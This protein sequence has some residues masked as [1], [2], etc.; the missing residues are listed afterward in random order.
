MYDITNE[1][2]FKFLKSEYKTLTLVS[3]AYLL[4]TLVMFWP[5][6][7]GFGSTIV[8]SGDAY[9]SM[10]NL[11][12]SG[13]ATFTL[14]TNLYF[15]SLL[16]S[17]IGA[18]LVVQDL[19]PLAGILGA[20]LQYFGLA[21]EY[22]TI[23]ILG[24]VL[25]GLFTYALAYYLARDRHAAFIAG[26]VFAFAPVHIAHAYAHLNWTSVEFIPLF[27]L[28]FLLFFK[29]RRQIFIFGAAIS[30]V[31]LTFIGDLLQSVMTIVFVA[32]FLVYMLAFDRKKVLD[33]GFFMGLC[34]IAVIFLLIGSP[35]L[36]HIFGSVINSG[37]V[38]ESL[39]VS[40][41]SQNIQFS[42]DL[43]AFFLPSSFNIVFNKIAGSYYQIY[44]ADINEK[45]SYIGY[46]ILFLSSL[47]ILYNYKSRRFPEVFLWLFI[48]IVF[49]WLALGPYIFLAG[50]NT[51][52]PGI[53]L[54]YANIP[55]FNLLREPGRFDVIAELGFAILAAFG[56]VYLSEAVAKRYSTRDVKTYL[57]AVLLA[58]ILIEYNG[59]PSNALAQQWYMNVSIP[60]VFY[61][62]GNSTQNYTVMLLPDTPN[63]TLPAFYLGESMYYQT[64][65]KKPIIGGYTSRENGT[66]YLSTYMIPLSIASGN[67]E[68]GNGFAYSS[69]I[70]ENYTRLTLLLLQEDNVHYVGIIK[71]AYNQGS[72]DELYH[73]LDGVFG[74]PVYNG[75]AVVLFDAQEAIL[76]NSGY[77]TA[78]TAGE[79]IPGS[80]LC[81]YGMQCNKTIT[82][83][84]FGSNVRGIEEY[85]PNSTSLTLDF[86][87]FSPIGSELYLYANGNLVKSINLTTVPRNYSA[88]VKFSSGFN[89]VILYVHNITSSA[90]QYGY[91]GIDN[92]T[93]S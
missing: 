91:Y 68:V 28:F 79:W 44:Q 70:I 4:I 73:Y 2:M 92:I 15:T 20:P 25:T 13:Y 50:T 5:V 27:I 89:Q 78:Y 80:S 16:Y 65:F 17:P 56:F 35:F 76:K 69:P 62:I 60:K 57:F 9:Q 7:F 71:Q 88:S 34:E 36:I 43:A 12:W 83:M 46:S 74:A 10:W 63:Q 86:N 93:F 26:T 21:A 31:L 19:M 75:N 33:K 81:S 8:H 11:W 41:I 54:I 87:A 48:I 64:A 30:F 72:F 14:H 90:Y 40:T 58:L 66:Q 67:L 37:I 18:N 59:M 55:L 53:Y 42:D 85:S 29:E 1:S 39:G 52:L 23:F 84:W 6:T 51:G 47:A 22:N 45:V 32:L 82:D 3:V 24:F 49:A 61:G 38:S 77:P